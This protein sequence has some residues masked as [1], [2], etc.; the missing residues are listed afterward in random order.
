[1][2]S[3]T[4]LNGYPLQDG[5]QSSRSTPLSSGIQRPTSLGFSTLREP[6]NVKRDHHLGRHERWDKGHHGQRENLGLYLMKRQKKQES[7]AFAGWIVIASI[8][9]IA[10]SLSSVVLTNERTLERLQPRVDTVR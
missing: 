5:Q 6:L 9:A 1:M 3:N 7:P 2:P 10:F 4:K 8:L